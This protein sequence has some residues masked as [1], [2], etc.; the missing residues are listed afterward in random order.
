MP[1]ME[2][3]LRGH[4][5]T[6]RGGDESYHAPVGNP[7]AA[8]VTERSD[9]YIS[10]VSEGPGDGR[11]SRGR[12]RRE[13]GFVET[14]PYDLSGRRSRDPRKR[15][16]RVVSVLLFVVGIALIAVA[17]G[18]WL[19]NQWQYHEQD[20]INE[21]LATFADVSDNGTTPPQVDWEALKAL[22][23]EVVGWVQ[24][25]GTAVNFPVYQASDNEKYLHTSAEGSYSLGGQVFMDYENTP[26]GMIDAQT[27]I[28]GH[29]LRNGAMFKP[30][31]DMTNQEMFDSVSTIWYVTEDA[32]YELEPLL[33]YETDASDTGARTFSFASD[34]DLHAYLTDLLS[35]SVT[36]RADAADV[37]SRTSHALTLCTCNYE[38]GDSG[39]TL[40]VCVPKSEAAGDAAA[41]GAADAAAGETPADETA[42]QTPT[43]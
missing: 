31:S 6:P 32:T 38:N 34:D 29:H 8:H 24:I 39:R 1:R 7:H 17:G 43:E 42:E 33:V 5:S 20:R 21:E 35:R 28:Y 14:D 36:S 15:V 9:G 40:L 37:I 26:P 12:R 27:V 25:P 10:V 41:S 2:G 18:M 3:G 19:Y 16:G 4:L 13:D 30:V 22:N 11:R 23:D